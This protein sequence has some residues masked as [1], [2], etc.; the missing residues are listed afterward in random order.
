MKKVKNQSEKQV[1]SDVVET[2]K[3]KPV[4]EVKYAFN[5]GILCAAVWGHNTEQGIPLFT[6]SLSRGYKDAETGEWKY[7][8]NSFTRDELLGLIAVLNAT[9][10]HIVSGALEGVTANE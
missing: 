3:P 2:L 9:Y 1:Q 7:S 5:G 10:N 4:H 8:G 6:V